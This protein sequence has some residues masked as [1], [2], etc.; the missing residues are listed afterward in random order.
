VRAGPSHTTTPTTI[1]KDPIGAASDPEK[2]VQPVLPGLA[3]F[4]RTQQRAS[5][6]PSP[7]THVPRLIP[8]GESAVLAR[9]GEFQA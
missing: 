6:H 3:R 2:P 5:A 9:S 7:V 4:L 1:R 8:E